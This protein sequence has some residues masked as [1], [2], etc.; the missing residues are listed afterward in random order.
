MFVSNYIDGYLITGKGT[1]II[2]SIIIPT[3]E[4][5]MDLSN[6]LEN[7]YYLTPNIDSIFDHLLAAVT[8]RD[9]AQWRLERER[10]RF[11][12][13]VSSIEPDKAELVGRSIYDIGKRLFLLLEKLSAYESGFLIYQK[14]RWV[15]SDLI[16]RKL[17]KDE[18]PELY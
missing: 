18:I 13:I 6:D 15:G 10:D 3:R 17:T 9:I 16:L 1:E 5:V 12:E 14:E 8:L 4:L 7:T 2:M 11:I